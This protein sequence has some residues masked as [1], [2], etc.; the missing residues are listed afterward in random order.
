[1]CRLSHPTINKR[2]PFCHLRLRGIGIFFHKDPTQSQLPSR[3]PRAFESSGLHPRFRLG[4]RRRLAFS[5]RG[6]AGTGA[7]FLRLEEG[8]VRAIGGAKLPRFFH[9]K[10]SERILTCPELRLE[11]SLR[12]VQPRATT[13]QAICFLLR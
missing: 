4:L 13:G 8:S 10:L 9:F 3:G 6:W 5:C 2:E 1:V 7:A 12:V 11:L